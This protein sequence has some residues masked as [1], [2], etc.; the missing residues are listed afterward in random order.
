MKVPESLL[1]RL[2]ELERNLA[3][4][5]PAGPVDVTTITDSEQHLLC[6]RCGR[7]FTE[8]FAPLAG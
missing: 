3:E 5:T 2:P 6:Q 8:P 1:E 4:T 7:V